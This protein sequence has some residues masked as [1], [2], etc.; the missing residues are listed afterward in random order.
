MSR[1]L[2]AARYVDGRDLRDVVRRLGR[3]EPE[4]AVAICV[5]VAS[6]SPWSDASP[7]DMIRP[8][9]RVAIRLPL[10]QL[11]ELDRIA[12]DEDRTRSAVV[13]D[14]V[15]EQLRDEV[16]RRARAGEPGDLPDGPPA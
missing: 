7:C 12:A 6:C 9:R 11:A 15:D 8:M 2:T 4:R 5:Q 3:L 16:A 10:R 14:I 13:R 1:G